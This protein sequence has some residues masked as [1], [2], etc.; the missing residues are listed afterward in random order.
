MNKQGRHGQASNADDLLRQAMAAMQGGRPD[1]A[2]RLA[3]TLLA[4]EPRHAAALH[5]CGLALLG[6][7]RP[8]D[9]IAPLEEACRQ[10]IDPVCE[11]NLAVALHKSGRSRDAARWLGQAT[12]RQPPFPHAFYQLSVVL[13][14]LRQLTDAESAI[15][16]AL[17]LAPG[18]GEFY[19]VLGSICLDRAK[20]NDAKV[21]FAR[22]LVNAPGHPSALFGL[23]TVSMQEGD[24]LQASERFRQALATDPIYYQARLNL[25][26]CLLELRHWDEALACLQTAVANTPAVY[27]TALKT[28]VTSGRGRFWL[29]PSVSA[30]HLRRGERAS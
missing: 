2:E 9:A 21:A 13:F 1:E 3:R 8:R 6:Q 17:E 19:V 30:T 26:A 14:S 23:G 4:R 11:T 27:A 22:A 16:R 25:G 28:L 24:F 10:R 7:R 5:V 15:R 20:W 29:K 12:R 18:I